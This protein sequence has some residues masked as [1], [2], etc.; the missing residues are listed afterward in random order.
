MRSTDHNVAVPGTGM[1]AVPRTQIFLLAT[2]WFNIPV[3]QRLICNTD[4]VFTVD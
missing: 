1:F 4:T 3:W 2:F